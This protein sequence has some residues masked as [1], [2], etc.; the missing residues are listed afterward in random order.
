M[1]VGWWNVVAQ[2]EKGGGHLT[3]YTL[4]LCGYLYFE[5]GWKPDWA[6]SLR[7]LCSTR[8]LD[9][10]LRRGN[11]C[12]QEEIQEMVPFTQVPRNRYDQD[13]TGVPRKCV[14]L[15]HKCTWKIA[16]KKQWRFQVVETKAL[17]GLECLV[18]WKVNSGR[19]M[20][21]GKTTKSLECQVNRK[22]P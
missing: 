13:T 16:W 1:G 22:E 19:W 21:R 18:W 4:V 14:V 2:S 7:A 3:C 11:K 12:G 8:F 15:N 5:C 17:A 6:C 20:C 10:K 9:M